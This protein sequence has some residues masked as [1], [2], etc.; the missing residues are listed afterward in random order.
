MR[1]RL[2]SDEAYAEAQ[3]ELEARINEDVLASAL[4]VRPQR[5]PRTADSDAL[6][7]DEDLSTGDEDPD[8][9]GPEVVYVHE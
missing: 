3:A 9:D 5:K 7:V 1:E 8:D 2:A 4:N 6:P